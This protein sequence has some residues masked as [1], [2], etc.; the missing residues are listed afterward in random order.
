MQAAS[1]DTPPVDVIASE[2]GL[3]AHGSTRRSGLPRG[4]DAPSDTH[5]PPLAAYS[6]GGSAGLDPEGPHRLPV[7]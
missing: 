4:L 6:C 7:L 1:P 5:R 2:A 3:L